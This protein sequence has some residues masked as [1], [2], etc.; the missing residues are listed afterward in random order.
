M[1]YFYGL[2]LLLYRPPVTSLSFRSCKSSHLAVF[3]CILPSFFSSTTR[4][5]VP[6]GLLFLLPPGFASLLRFFIKKAS[7]VRFTAFSS[8]PYGGT[9]PLRF[10]FEI[11]PPF[12]LS[13]LVRS[14]LF[15][16]PSRG[17]RSSSFTSVFYQKT[18]IRTL[19]SWSIFGLHVLDLLVFLVE[20]SPGLSSSWSLRTITARSPDLRSSLP[21]YQKGSFLPRSP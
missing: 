9:T 7:V 2:F 15:A 18:C 12:V 8:S 1:F 13:G 17:A 4:P 10:H 3:L 16:L 20:T 5:F 14:F 21:F 11:I 6:F 19:P